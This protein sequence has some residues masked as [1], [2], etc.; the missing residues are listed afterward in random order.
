MIIFLILTR[1]TYMNVSVETDGSYTEQGAETCG[2]ANATNK[3]TECCLAF[4]PHRT[5]DHTCKRCRQ[6]KET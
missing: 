1:L 2:E 5:T 6:M 3:L 4:K